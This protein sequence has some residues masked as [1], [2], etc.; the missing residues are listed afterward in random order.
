MTINKLAKVKD[1]IIEQQTVFKSP[2]ASKGQLIQ[3]RDKLIKDY[4]LK[5][6]DYAVTDS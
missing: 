1:R 6:K 3:K 2:Q 4:K 5:K